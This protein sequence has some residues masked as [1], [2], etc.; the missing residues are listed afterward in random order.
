MN[1]KIISDSAKKWGSI[2]ILSGVGGTLVALAVSWVFATT[3]KNTVMFTPLVDAI[4]NLVE[5]NE[6]RDEKNAQ[7]HQLIVTKL[8]AI[9]VKSLSN[10][11]MLEAV[12]RNCEQNEQ[13]IKN[14]QTAHIRNLEWK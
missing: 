1:K 7:E 6:K 5:S 8:E 3:F 2:T 11:I 12:L 13:D 14:C 9:S 10:E 4:D